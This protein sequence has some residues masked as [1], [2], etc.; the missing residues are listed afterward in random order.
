MT[1]NNKLDYIADQMDDLHT[2]IKD[3][4]KQIQGIAIDMAKTREH[5]KG[6]NGKVQR[7]ETSL[8]T[9]HRKVND[10]KVSIAKSGTAGAG[11]GTLVLIVW[12]SVKRFMGH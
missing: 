10:N 11:A 3:N 2:E 9:L 8:D 7:H 4:N 12:E 5:M 1:K 6:L